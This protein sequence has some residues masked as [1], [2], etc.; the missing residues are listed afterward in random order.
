MRRTLIVANRT[1][2][3]PVLLQEVA[4]RNAE[5]TTAFTLLVPNAG[6]GRDWTLENALKELR[7]AAKGPN[8]I[9]EAHV[10]GFA[11]DADPFEAVKFALEQG[12]Y[13]DV[14]ISTLPSRVSEWLKKDLP[15]R[16]EALDVP[17]TVITPPSGRG[18]FSLFAKG[19]GQ[20]ERG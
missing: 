10:D 9:L 8:G 13:D 12:E 20:H 7:K 4:R 3:T 2:S 11:G 15:S 14:I 18:G 16:V 1:A 5:R 17:V 19:A 6:S